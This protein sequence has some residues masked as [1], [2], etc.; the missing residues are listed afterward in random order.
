MIGIKSARD[1]DLMRRSG[2][3]LRDCFLEL[4]KMVVP[5]VTTAELDRAAEDFIRSRGAEPA[6]KGYHGYPATICASVNEQVVHGIPGDRRLEAGDI[7]GIDMGAI[8]EGFYSDATRSFPVGEIGEEPRKLLRV[9]KEALDLAIDKAR[10]GNH[11]SDISHAVQMHAERH[12]YSVVRVLVGHG[13]GRRLHEEPQIPNYGPPGEGPVLEAGMVMAIE[14]MV[15]VGTCEVLTRKDNWTYVT[16]DG[17]LS[18]HFEDTVAVT[19]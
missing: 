8:R 16:V 7:I 10:P 15:N 6:F 13:I 14:P 17:S 12:G 18:C 5:G 4:E 9:T 1:L 2:E 19:N 3:I 11:L